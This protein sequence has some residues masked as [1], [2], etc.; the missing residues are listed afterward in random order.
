MQL[1]FGPAF[2]ILATHPLT[3]LAAALPVIQPPSCSNQA[4]QKYIITNQQ[5]N[6]PGPPQT[7]AYTAP[8]GGKRPLTPLYIAVLLVYVLPPLPNSRFIYQHILRFRVL[9]LIF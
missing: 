9:W 7:G 4:A 2:A 5:S 8:G 6:V 3:C 1:P